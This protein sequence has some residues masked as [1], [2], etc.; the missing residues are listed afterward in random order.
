MRITNLCDADK[1]PDHEVVTYN[2]LEGE[3]VVCVQRAGIVV[4]RITVSPRGTPQV[5]VPDQ[6]DQRR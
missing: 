1:L 6:P 3:L 5:M 2:G 4:I